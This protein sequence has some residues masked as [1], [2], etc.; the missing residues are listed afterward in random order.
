MR[1]IALIG[2]LV[3]SALLTPGPTNAQWGKVPTITIAALARDARIPLVLEAG[4]FWNCQLAE[5]GTPFRL[6][7]VTQTM[8]HGNCS[9]L[10]WYTY[11]PSST[12]IAKPR[13][14]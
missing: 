10:W 3:L 12:P 13:S 9:S 14:T 8:P 2:V 11:S 6:G 7:A 4:E 1:P 5:I